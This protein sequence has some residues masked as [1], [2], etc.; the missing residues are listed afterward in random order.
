MQPFVLACEANICS[1]VPT[2]QG[3]SASG[4]VVAFVA[5]NQHGLHC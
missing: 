4:I 3:V 2:L 1:E 5:V